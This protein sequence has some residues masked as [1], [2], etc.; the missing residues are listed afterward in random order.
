MDDT[1]IDFRKRKGGH[2][3]GR[4]LLSSLSLS[5][6][7]L[8]YNF[9]H[10]LF[11]SVKAVFPHAPQKKTERLVIL[12]FGGIGNH[13]MLTP[14]LRCLKRTHPKLNIHVVATS[15][16]C[17]EVLQENPA[18]ESVSVVNI[19]KMNRLSQYFRAG[20]GIRRLKPHAVLAPAGTNPVAG[21]LISFFSGASLRIG[22]DWKGR[23]FLYT[24]RIQVNLDICEV[25]QNIELAKFLHISPEPVFP[26]L[27]LTKDEINEAHQWLSEFKIPAGTK[28]LGI[29]PGS[30]KE[31]EW[32]RWG[33]EKF[34]EVAKRIATARKVRPIFFFGPEE[35]DFIEVIE[36]AD[37]GSAIIVKGNGSIRKTAA[38]ISC[39]HLLLS[40]DSGLRHIAQALGVRTVGIF[41]PTS[42]VKNDLRGETNKIIVQENV[43][44]A[45]CH[46]TG[47][48]LACGEQR[49][50]LRLISPDRVV[51]LVLGLL[52]EISS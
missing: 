35:N 44:C 26:H 52:Y 17:A 27:Y 32:K 31:Q 14:A 41:G 18:I 9:L 46:Y 48:W 25:E 40:N 13:L 10:L 49:P 4:S 29:H 33:I 30:G 2:S 34:A 21:S 50:C 5:F 6:S 38:I 37:I 20:Q 39:C 1:I 47:W 12:G 15:K 28:L 8:V 42:V 36:K 43:L 45:P 3:R 16:V 24:H 7:T 22:E 23:G 51:S 19:G 11:I